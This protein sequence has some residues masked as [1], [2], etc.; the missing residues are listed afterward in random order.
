[1]RA[2]N[3]VHEVTQLPWC[4]IHPSVLFNRHHGSSTMKKLVVS[5]NV[6]SIACQIG[7]PFLQHFE[8]NFVNQNR[9]DLLASAPVTC[10]VVAFSDGLNKYHV[11]MVCGV[12]SELTCF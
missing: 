5:G 2:C 12:L 8:A 11:S 3:E 9:K 10:I 4:Y 6:E 1:M 7:Y